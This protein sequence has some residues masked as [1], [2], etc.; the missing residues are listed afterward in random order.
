[1]YEI[2]LALKL[3]L[4]LH[5]AGF[6]VSFTPGFSVGLHKIRRYANYVTMGYIREDVY[7]AGPVGEYS[8]V[9]LKPELTY[10]IEAGIIVEKKLGNNNTLSLGLQY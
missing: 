3:P 7:G 6:S 4:C 9:S 8:N 2:P 5:N 1:M 10:N